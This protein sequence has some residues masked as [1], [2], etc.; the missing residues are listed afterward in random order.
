MKAKKVMVGGMASVAA[1][2][3]GSQ[4]ADAQDWTGAYAGLSVNSNQGSLP[5][6]DDY[7]L[8]NS[9]VAGAFVG[10]RWAAGNVI[11]G[12]EIAYQGSFGGDADENSGNPEDYSFNRLVD[13]KLSIGK[14]V[15]QVLV[16]GFA[17][18]SSG[19]VEAAADGQNYSAVGANFGLGADYRVSDKF[20]VGA[21][22]TRRVMSGYDN[23]SAG[24]GTL[25]LRASFHF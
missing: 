11:V 16:Y 20:S 14:P 6:S 25:A 19:N 5:W 13:A 22:Y 18:V 3:A 9:A 21:E 15:G 12:A 1:I 10:A 17:G 23:A 4:A 24:N 7:K 8:E 2:A